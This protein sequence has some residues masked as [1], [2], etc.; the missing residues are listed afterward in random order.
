MAV[1]MPLHDCRYSCFVNADHSK[2]Q[3]LD[4]HSGFLRNMLIT[5]QRLRNGGAVLFG[6][7]TISTEQGPHEYNHG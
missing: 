5:M 2:K 1:P 6:S 4:L 3:I 7:S